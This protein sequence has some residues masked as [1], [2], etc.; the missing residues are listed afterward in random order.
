MISLQ[1]SFDV[2]LLDSTYTV[3][4]RPGDEDQ[5]KSDVIVKLFGKTRDNKSITIIC[6]DFKPYFH[7]YEPSAEL[8]KEL[9]SK[10]DVLKI[11]DV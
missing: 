4:P 10:D 1:A 3:E 2:R 8:R 5:N 11:E 9:Q 6:P 7:I